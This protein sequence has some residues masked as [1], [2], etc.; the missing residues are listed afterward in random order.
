MAARDIL[1]EGRVQG[2]GFRAWTQSR[3]RQHGLLGWVRN[4]TDGRVQVFVQGPEPAM[5]AFI[6][7]LKTGPASASVSAVSFQ[8]CVQGDVSGFTVRASASRP[9]AAPEP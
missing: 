4:L 5:Q 9:E 8:P 7:E 2:V 1:I 3:A 6:E